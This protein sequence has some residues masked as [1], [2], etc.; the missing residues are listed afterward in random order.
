MSTLRVL[1]VL[2][3]A[4]LFVVLPTA[5][6]SPE[7][8]PEATAEP[9]P[10]NSL[11]ALLDAM[12][13]RECELSTFTCVTITVP[14][15]HNNP[16]N[17]QTIDLVY[18]VSPAEGES[19]GLYVTATGGPG[20]SGLAAAD[21]YSSYFDPTIWE[22]Y[23]LVFFDQRGVGESNGLDCTEATAAWHLTDVHPIDPAQEQAYLDTV[24]TF[25]EDC[26]AEIDADDILPYLGT[27]Q[28]IHDLEAFRQIIGAPTMVLY[29][30]SYGTQFVQDY[31]TAYPEAISTLILDGVVDLTLTGE[32]FYEQ[33]TQAFND[34]LTA[35]LEECNADMACVTDFGG[36]AVAFYDSLAADLL[37]SP[38]TVEFQ[39]PS[40]D[41][42]SRQYTRSML[43][44]SAY[45]M[46]YERDARAFFLRVL[47][48]AARGDFQPL[49]RLAYMDYSYDP[50]TETISEAFGD[51]EA[52]Y[53]LIECNDYTF[54]GGLG[55]ESAQAWLA[56]GNAVEQAV[57]RLNK[58]FYTDLPCVFWPVQGRAERPAP[59]AGGDYPT[60]I[61][62]TTTDPATPVGN[63]YNVFR[64]L[65][66]ANAD[67]YMITL[68]GGP[69]V[70]I[71]RENAC[72]DVAITRW[73][74]EGI[75]PAARE[76]IC[77]GT[78]FDAYTPL[79]PAT[80]ADFED[81]EAILL[82]VDTEIQSL[83][84]Y[85]YWDLED[86]LTV[87]CPYGGVLT[88]DATD[89]GETFGFSDCA[90]FDGVVL[91]GSGEWIYDETFTLDVALSGAADGQ[92]VYLR[93]DAAGMFTV[94]G[95]YNS[96]P[97]SLTP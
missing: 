23:D 42:E 69:H 67:V 27:E 32:A 60:F 88:A 33:Q 73:M 31:A 64:R 94:T 34:V 5:A 61:L 20:L 62:N 54:F 86:T 17:G 75:R 49:L 21:W 29:G 25:V 56:A 47:A 48:A 51:G 6:Q 92:V 91:N 74:V 82:A 96:A 11:A 36:D 26:I 35:T 46:A 14:L 41:T 38:I 8:T 53:Y 89:D 58:L 7:V 2:V 80:Y 68:Q 76:F 95:D 87:G 57:P 72:P 16:D 66:D 22:H 19:Y 93:D 71:G 30:E 77:E 37:E 55:E 90:F 65:A 10:D 45:N 15:D 9:A 78:M 18:A 40:G 59:F 97:V 24:R 70:I 39:L 79:S 43:E 4:A 81:I 28:A 13:G 50:Q 52:P 83:P 63:G 3:L 12:G 1:F 85:Y 44:Y 84:E